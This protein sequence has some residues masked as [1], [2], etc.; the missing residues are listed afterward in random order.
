MSD[1]LIDSLLW[2]MSGSDPTG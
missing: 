2:E 1:D